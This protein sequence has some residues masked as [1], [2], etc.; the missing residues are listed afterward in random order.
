VRRWVLKFGPRIARKLR[1]CRPRPS[2]RFLGKERRFNRRF[3]RMCSHY[4]VDPVACTPAAGWEKV[5]RQF[6]VTE[7]PQLN[8][9]QPEEPHR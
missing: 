6:S 7:Y 5:S 4:L 9:H 3:L 2:D 1:R 8:R